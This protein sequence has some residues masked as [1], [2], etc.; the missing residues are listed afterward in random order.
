MRRITET[1]E[2]WVMLKITIDGQ[3]P[4]YKVFGSWA[5]GYLN[6]DHWQLNKIGR[7]HV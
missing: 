2:S 3:E 1:P 6:G 5:G 4:Y 7:A